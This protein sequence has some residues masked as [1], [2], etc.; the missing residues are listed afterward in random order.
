MLR[1]IRRVKTPPKVSMP[2]TAGHVQQQDVLDLALQY[3]AWI[4]APMGD[5]IRVDA[6]VRLLAEDLFDRL[7]TLA[8]GHAASGITSSS[9]SEA[10]VRI[11]ER[12]AARADR[13]LDQ[14]IDEGFQFRPGQLD[15]ECFGPFWSAVMNGRV[16]SVCTDADS[17]TLAF[18]RSF[19]R[20][21]ASC[22]CAGRC[23]APLNSSA[24]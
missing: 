21:K 22:R 8:C 6:A 2:R 18:R 20:C 11:L 10:L 9:T 7:E 19:G 3:A 5:L 12:V 14:I 16:D 13:P 4:A 1:S 17:S 24:R 15:V 23:P